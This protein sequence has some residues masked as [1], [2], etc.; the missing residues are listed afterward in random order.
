MQAE[1]SMA[2]IMNE[3]AGA[4]GLEPSTSAVTGQVSDLSSDCPDISHVSEMSISPAILDY[5]R[6]LGVL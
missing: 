4:K 5:S 1:G 6:A 3:V 2:A